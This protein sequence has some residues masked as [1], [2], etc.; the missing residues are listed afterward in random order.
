MATTLRTTGDVADGR[1]RLAPLPAAAGDA[2]GRAGC[3]SCPTASTWHSTVSAC[4]R[5]RL[6]RS[7]PRRVGGCTFDDLH[8]LGGG[9][10]LVVDY[11]D[12]YPCAQ[13]FVPPARVRVPGADDRAD[14]G[15]RRGRVPADPAG[16]RV[17]RPLRRLGRGSVNDHPPADL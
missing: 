11:R 14:R 5:G 9:R 4:R 17:H 2:E 10:R 7:R 16:R 13:V 6:P 12:G 3:S 8:R 1:V 15:G